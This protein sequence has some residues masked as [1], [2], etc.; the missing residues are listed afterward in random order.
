M[1]YC[2]PAD[3]R[4]VLNPTGDPAD[5]GTAS[6]MADPALQVAIDEITA[7]IDARLSR[8][9]TVPFAQTP[10]LI[11]RICRDKAAWLAMLTQRGGDPVPQGDPVTARQAAAEQLLAN[12]VSGI[13]VLEDDVPG[14]LDLTPA[15]ANAYDGTMFS[16]RDVG[17]RPAGGGQWRP[18]S[19]WPF[20]DGPF[21]DP[22]WPGV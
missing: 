18:A 16:P 14:E 17:M 11:F 20:S 5:D 6:G 21:G 13:I 19:D 22:A 10:Q 12:V 7:E 1:A 4:A 8:R 15:V 9:Y 3:V 2:T